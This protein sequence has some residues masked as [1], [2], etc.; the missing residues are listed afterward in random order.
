M[1]GICGVFHYAGGT[2]RPE[3]VVAIAD[4]MAHRGPDDRGAWSDDHAALAHRRLSLLDL[5]PAGHQPMT[6]E[7]GT[8]WL[9]FNGEIY[10]DEFLRRHLQGRGHRLRGRSDSELL[11][12]LYEDHGAAMLDRLRG[13][14]AFGLYDTADRRLLLARDRLGVK[15][16]YWHDDG[17]RIVFASELPALMRHCDVPREIDFAALLDVL[18]FGYVPSPRT[19]WKGV[20]KLPA[21]HQV[22][23]DEGGARESAWW[24]MPEQM[25]PPADAATCE[26]ELRELIRDAVQ[27]RLRADVPVGV[28][29]S[30]GLDSSTVAAWAQHLSAGPV[31]A[32]T[33]AFPDDDASEACEAHALARALGMDHRVLDVTP[34]AVT[35][36]PRLI[37]ALGEPFAD[38][39]LVPTWALAGAAAR[40]VKAVLS[41]DGGDEV[42]GGYRT[43]PAALRHAR[44]DMLPMALRRACGAAGRRLPDDA[45]LARKLRR[46]PFGIVDRHADAMAAHTPRE[47]TLL[48]PSLR[49]QLTTHDPHQQYRHRFAE[50]AADCRDVAGLLRLDADTFLA[51]DVLAKVDAASM[52][53]SLEVRPPLLDHRLVEWMARLPLHEKVRVG[54][55]K[56]LLRR[57]M[58]P[59]LPEHVLRRPKRGFA[60]PLQ[61]WLG[62]AAGQ[63]ARAMVRDSAG[64]GWFDAKVLARVCAPE[65][66]HDGR[67]LRQLWTL[68]CIELWAQAHLDAAP[69]TASPQS[70]VR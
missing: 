1:C 28:L 67:T 53:H 29:L 10:D 60:A 9:V 43:Y 19:I 22:V 59:L 7:A 4:A 31:P 12:H 34:D 21:G 66:A 25:A 40:E 51:D 36:L 20:R 37:A 63:H 42:F 70:L 16:L 57:A 26:H 58:R 32:Y 17:R 38:S 50:H 8:C 47:L 55:T 44:L 46:V 3:R 56:S 35:T 6:N 48:A 61:R 49:E 5:S 13:E 18:A 14:F 15:P 64:R 54:E 52:L 65:R 68:W 33:V 41:G 30:A 11:L 27:V 2:P 24:R 39:S 23:V 45:T 62:G 69:R